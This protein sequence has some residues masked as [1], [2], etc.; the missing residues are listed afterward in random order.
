M[1]QRKLQRTR[2][3]DCP[4]R[5]HVGPLELRRMPDGKRAQQQCEACGRGVGPRIDLSTVEPDAAR[6]LARWRV[7]RLG[8]GGG[9]SKR[10]EYKRFLDSAQWRETRAR[11]LER[12]GYR[13]RG[14]DCGA[15]ATTVHHIRYAPIL[16]QTPD[17]DLCAACISCNL[18]EAEFRRSGGLVRHG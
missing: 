14:L 12:D 18:R 8:S 17:S 3:R 13:C 15:P 9:N 1:S 7:P 5:Q 16:E 4:A 6:S 2:R 10:R 11:V